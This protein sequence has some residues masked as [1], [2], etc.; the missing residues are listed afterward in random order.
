[1]LFIASILYQIYAR[2]NNA[3]KQFT[4]NNNVIRF[5]IKSREKLNRKNIK[6]N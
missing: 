6:R 3:I 4:D 1:M 5:W 2:D